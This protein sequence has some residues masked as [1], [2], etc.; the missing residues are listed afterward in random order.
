MKERKTNRQH[1][2]FFSNRPARY[3]QSPAHRSSIARVRTGTSAAESAGASH[4]NRMQ[5]NQLPPH[6]PIVGPASPTDAPH[7]ISNRLGVAAKQTRVELYFRS[8]GCAPEYAEPD[9]AQP[10]ATHA[11]AS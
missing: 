9:L 6:W 8:V 1:S 5:P 11:P 10:P 2:A 3:S 7:P 4:S